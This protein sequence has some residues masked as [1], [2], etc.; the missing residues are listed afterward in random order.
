LALKR[1]KMPRNKAGKK[2]KRE[3]ANEVFSLL[4]ADTSH[5]AALYPLSLSFYPAFLLPPS[6]VRFRGRSGGI[7][8]TIDVA[9]AETTY[10]YL[11]QRKSPRPPPA[12]PPTAPP[13]QLDPDLNRHGG[14]PSLLGQRRRLGPR[15]GHQAQH[16]L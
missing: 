5:A 3:S 2:E 9:A 6:Q 12:K 14:D 10:R 1:K 15:H 8:V 13:P 7:N 11:T 16:R 4:L